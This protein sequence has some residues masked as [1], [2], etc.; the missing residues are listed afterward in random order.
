MLNVGDKGNPVMDWSFS[1]DNYATTTVTSD[2]YR[3]KDPVFIH[4]CPTDLSSF[5]LSG[6]YQ[7]AGSI[8]K[9]QK[10]NAKLRWWLSFPKMTRI[11]SVVNVPSTD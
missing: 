10:R 9:F 11:N 3:R 6:Y 1:F 8:M 2:Y 4:D 5:Y 7:G